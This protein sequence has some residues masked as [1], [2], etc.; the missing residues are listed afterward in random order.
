VAL[1]LSDVKAP[2][3]V[4]V[5]FG[6]RAFFRAAF[7]LLALA[8]IAL[9]LTV[10][11]GEKQRRYADYAVS[12]SKTHQQILAR[13]RHPSGQL[14]LLNP[15]VLQ[16]DPTP[17]R[18]I[19]LPYGAL[20]FDDR[21][22]ARQAVENAGCQTQYPDGSSL[23][24]AIGNNP[25][26]GGFVYLVG[27]FSLPELVPL[28]Q[29]EFDVTK[30]H[31]V[32]VSVNI[33]EQTYQWIAPFQ[34]LLDG[35]SIDPNRPG[36]RGRLTG[37][38]ADEP[39]VSGTKSIRDFR[40]WLW[41][42]GLADNELRRTSISI[43]L[44][45]EPWR[46]QIFAKQMT[47]WPPA[48]LDQ[49]TVRLQL[50]APGNSILFDSNQAGGSLPFSWN[51]IAQV[52]DPGETLSISRID[53]KQA[54]AVVLLKGKDSQETPTVIPVWVDRL[55]TSL[56][57]LAVNT[58]T[59]PSEPGSL[60]RKQSLQTS[61]GQYDVELSAQA[62]AIDRELAAVTSRVSWYLFAILGA[63]G[64]TWLALE[65]RIIRRVTTLT[66]RAAQ[67]TKSIAEH[68]EITALEIEDIKGSDE[69]GSLSS[70]L[71]VLLARVKDDVHRAQLRA[72]QERDTWQAVGH[73]IMSPLQS[74]MVL[75]K[76]PNDPSARYIE[77]M[78][79]A[80]KVLYGNASPTEAFSA[81][82]PVLG[83]L[84]LNQ[85]L[86]ELCQS[87]NELGLAPIEFIKPLQK[88]I[89]RADEYWLEDVLGHLLS[90]AD[91]HRTPNST[92]TLTLLVVGN[93][94]KLQ[95]A[96]KGDVIADELL[97][98]IFEYGVSYRDSGFELPPESVASEVRRENLRGQGL[99]VVR[100]YLSK[101]GASIKAK[102]IDGG[103]CFE[104]V[105]L[106]AP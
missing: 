15:G 42:E 62:Q 77:R 14:A 54:K 29:M 103:V 67:V 7:L 106:L 37:Y 68:S 105:F 79:Q 59:K 50:L 25:Y 71:Q 94:V 38:N 40:A 4:K 11:V 76:S 8:V 16:R 73:E 95:L 51:E 3:D 53:N 88:V 26:A 101:M 44:P 49:M 98:K 2:F 78:Q 93:E 86:T 43:R 83:T 41:Q 47:V 12:L 81:A 72:Q 9:A 96:N 6:L 87:A 97:E 34:Y 80:I 69:L 99:F 10:L 36:V 20:D 66:S 27:S 32:L 1:N 17:L 85:F 61:V 30:A 39:I 91:R 33:K 13:L 5:P 60:A 55:I 45:I 31:R 63:I 35:T 23:C 22:K 48:D 100:T 102:N 46:D 89:V 18:P 74:L 75:H 58:L 70:S 84:D 21:L 65:L 52:L 28:P 56:P 64:L 90:N 19:L 92:V 57:L 82:T 24:V 104:I